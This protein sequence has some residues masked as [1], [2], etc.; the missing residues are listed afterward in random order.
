MK[1]FQARYGLNIASC[2]PGVVLD[3]ATAFSQY[4]HAPPH[5]FIVTLCTMKAHTPPLP[6][7]YLPIKK[8]NWTAAVQYEG[9]LYASQLEADSSFTPI[10]ALPLLDAFGVSRGRL[11]KSLV[12]SLRDKLLARVE[13]CTD[14]QYVRVA[15]ATW[16]WRRSLWLKVAAYHGACAIRFLENAHAALVCCTAVAA[17]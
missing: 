4:C 16:G 8:R 1:E 7:F 14:D 5:V 10:P 12:D 13:T 15:M 3:R 17:L 11:Y 2:Q 9:A 6:P